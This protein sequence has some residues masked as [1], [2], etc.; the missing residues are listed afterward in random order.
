MALEVQQITKKLGDHLAV[1][2]VDFRV[3]EGEFFV[4]LGTSGSG[5]STILRLIAGL[6]KPDSGQILLNNINIVPLPSR[7]RNLGMVFQDYGLYPN[8]NVY[9][10]IAYGLEARGVRRQE[11]EQRVTEAARRLAIDVHLKQPIT[12][13]SGGEQQRVALARALAK[14]AAAFLFDEPLSNLD[15]KLR[16]GARRDIQTVHRLKGKPSLYVTHDQ[17]EAFALADRIGV[18]SHGVMQQIGTAEALLSNPANTFVAGFLGS[19]AINL[20]TGEI[21]R[22]GD[23]FQFHADQLALRLPSWWSD[24]LDGYH[25]RRVVAGIRPGIFGA[26]H[27]S[28]HNGHHTSV[29]NGTVVDVQ[30]LLGEIAVMVRVSPQTQLTAVLDDLESAAWNIGHQVSLAVDTDQILLFD[31]DTERSLRPSKPA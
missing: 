1:N 13:L 8:M 28:A 20:I 12:D 26:A 5:K 16:F 29:V 22:D 4:L 21:Q 2:N 3:E 27:E 23:Q 24:A 10:N 6:E 19:P 31:I 7:D 30:D 14:D 17:T 18:L 9:Q 25:N 15:P 11:V